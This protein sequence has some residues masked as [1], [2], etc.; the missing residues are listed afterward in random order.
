MYLLQ[1]GAQAGAQPADISNDC[2]ETTAVHAF[3]I[4]HGRE[5]LAA[6]R[7]KYPQ[8]PQLVVNPLHTGSVSSVM[9]GRVQN[10]LILVS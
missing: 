9:F 3:T 5:D 8:Y 6:A 2:R 10:S 7:H 4:T 1:F